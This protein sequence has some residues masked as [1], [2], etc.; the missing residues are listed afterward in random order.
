MIILLLLSLVNV[1][2]GP[3]WSYPIVV[4]EEPNSGY[5]VQ[6]ISM[7]QDGRFHMFWADYQLDPRIGYKVFLLDGTTVVPDTMVSRDTVSGYLSWPVVLS[8]SLMAFWREYNPVYYCIRSLEDGSEVTPA[9]YLFTEYTD[10]PYIRA[11]PD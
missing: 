8:D 10:L 9:T 3:G 5:P 11:C 4:T 6:Y 2:V 1:T 7:D